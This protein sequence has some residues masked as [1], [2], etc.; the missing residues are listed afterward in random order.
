MCRS[1]AVVKRQRALHI[2]ADIWPQ[3]ITGAHIESYYSRTAIKNSAQ[4]LHSNVD[5]EV[6]VIGG[7]LAGINTANSLAERGVKVVLLEANKLG[8]AASGRNG[9]FAHPGYSLDL[10]SLAKLVGASHARALWELSVDSV[11]MMR[12][13]IAKWQTEGRVETANSVQPGM[14]VC[15]WFDNAAGTHAE[16]V[17]GNSIIGS[18]YWQFWD[19]STV[20]Q[21]YNTN[22][23]YDAVY[24]PAAFHF[25][26]LNYALEVARD[27]R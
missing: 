21:K 4:A 16:V 11:D 23:Y 19:R 14:V 6:C 3:N 1:I 18:D 12:A 9:G 5:C 8:W 27:A 2:G 10:F 15:S 24:D 17:A 26:S 25:H 20:R 22:K 13:R 7:G